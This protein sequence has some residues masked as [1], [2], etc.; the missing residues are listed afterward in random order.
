MRQDRTHHDT[1][2]ERCAQCRQDRHPD[3]RNQA[4]GSHNF[5]HT[6]QDQEP[7]RKMVLLKALHHLLTTRH[8]RVARR[9]ECQSQYYLQNKCNPVHT[10]SPFY[11][12]SS[13]TLSICQ[14]L[15]TTKTTINY[16][17]CFCQHLLTMV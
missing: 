9:E 13:P 3:T 15:L 5:K 16:L 8:L 14:H 7:D 11:G 12:H 4:Q 1:Y 17:I 10:S 2:Q 6:G